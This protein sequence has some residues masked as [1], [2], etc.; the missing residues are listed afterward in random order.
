M[1][2]PVNNHWHAACILSNFKVCFEQATPAISNRSAWNVEKCKK[3][4]SD[5]DATTATC[6]Q[7]LHCLCCGEA[8]T[9]DTKIRRHRCPAQ[10][11][12]GRE[13]TKANNKAAKEES[14]KKKEEDVVAKLE[15]AMMES[16]AM[17]AQ[18]TEEATKKTEEAKEA[19]AKEATAKKEAKT[20]EAKAKLAKEKEKKAKTKPAK[21]NSS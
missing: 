10:R 21:L 15:S 16:V 9:D 2:S 6:R 7:Q 18:T 17:C 1:L 20:K 13:K 14:K 12:R 5:P 3:C 19:K 8:P 11:A 4:M